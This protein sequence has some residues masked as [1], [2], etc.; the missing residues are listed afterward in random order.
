MKDKML[1]LVLSIFVFLSSTIAITAVLN[2]VIPGNVVYAQGSA[3]CPNC[4]KPLT[5]IEDYK[6]WYC[7]SEGKYMDAGFDPN[8]KK[9]PPPP[10][11]PVKKLPPPPASASKLPPPPAAK[12]LPPPPVSGVKLPPPPTGA[13]K[14]PP[15]PVSGVKLPPPPVGAA[16]LPPPVKRTSRPAAPASA[17]S[18]MVYSFDTLDNFAPSEGMDQTIE[19]SADY[20]TE[21]DACFK[22]I[23]LGGDYPGFE[24]YQAGMIAYDWTGYTSLLLDVYN[25]GPDMRAFSMVF[26]NDARDRFTQ[27]EML[28]KRGANTLKIDLRRAAAKLKN[29]LKMQMIVCY[30]EGQTQP[31][32]KLPITLYLDNLRV[33][34]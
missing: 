18:T 2:T 22:L 12:K 5:Y 15:P 25:E 3:A 17:A 11:P 9:T 26:D 1:R 32:I 8:K 28:L 16:K 23:C 34:K 30:V 29:N 6:R 20:S 13:A 21:G 4:S 14:L 27:D 33:V 7:E 24:I 19:L 31:P 10:P